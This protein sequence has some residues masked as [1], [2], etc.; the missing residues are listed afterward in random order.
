M[1][2]VALRPLETG[3]CEMKR[4]YTVPEARGPG[5]GRALAE[6]IIEQG[7]N[8]RYSRMRLDTVSGM[9][10]AN[11]L[12]ASLGFQPIEPYCHNPLP[13]ALFFELNL[14]PV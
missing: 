3:I 5:L 12:Y 10:E 7:R 8:L 4:L 13:E 14:E 6:A 2:C 11:G 1:G 9:R